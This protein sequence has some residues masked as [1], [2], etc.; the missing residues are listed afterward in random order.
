MG[1]DFSVWKYLQAKANM[2]R[3]VFLKDS[4]VGN[5][6]FKGKARGEGGMAFIVLLCCCFCEETTFVIPVWRQIM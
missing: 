3:R 4:F 1:E 5:G 2:K 6:L